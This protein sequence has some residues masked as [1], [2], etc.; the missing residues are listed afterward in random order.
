MTR[1]MLVLALGTLLSVACDEALTDPSNVLGDTWRLVSLQRGNDA[2]IAVTSPD[3]YT[4]RFG[5][6]GQ[7]QVRSDCNSCGGTYSL[8]GAALDVGPLACTKV[9]CGD[10]SLDSAFV[11][12]L[13]DA[14][15]VSERGNELV[16]EGG[17]V[18]LRFQQ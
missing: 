10:T 17:G 16:V 14:A 5:E 18:T 13:Q 7:M 9:F 4:L 6:G 3:R 1:G 2:P 11:G 8:T 12:A 15:V